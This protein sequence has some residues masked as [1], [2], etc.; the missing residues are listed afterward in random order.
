[1]EKHVADLSSTPRLSVFVRN[2]VGATLEGSSISK[3]CM[4]L[5]HYHLH[6]TGMLPTLLFLHVSEY[7]E[8]DVPEIWLHLAEIIT[9]M[10]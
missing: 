8:A 3:E 1:M 4:S 10:I 2:A 6:E 5:L 9:P 7:I